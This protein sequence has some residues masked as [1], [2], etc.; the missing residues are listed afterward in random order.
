MKSKFVQISDFTV[1]ALMNSNSLNRHNFQTKTDMNVKMLFSSKLCTKN[2]ILDSKMQNQ[3]FPFS[4]AYLEEWID[5][6]DTMISHIVYLE[7]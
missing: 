7:G 6:F 4:A 3:D 2:K 1:K 5:D